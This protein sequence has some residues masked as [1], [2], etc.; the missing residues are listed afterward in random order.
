MRCKSGHFTKYEQ[1]Y[2][3]CC[4]QPLNLPS[5]SFSI[6]HIDRHKKEIFDAYR[7]KFVALTPEEWLRQNFL[8]FLTE[9]K[10]YPVSLLAVEK[11]LQVQKRQRRFDAVAY[12]TDGKPL[13]LMEFKAPE[14]N[15]T[16]KTFE[17]IAAYNQLLKVKYLI[18][19]NGLKH[20]CCF[21]DF[22][23][24]KILFLNNIPT[25]DTLE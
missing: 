12:G 8:R 5:Y 25:F 17:Q 9:T 11:G 1:S 2:Y 24:N 16:Q 23:K 10:G 18:V 15:I 22:K 21:I 4:M 13:M 20:Y 6:K 19:S 14:V 7:K 3:F